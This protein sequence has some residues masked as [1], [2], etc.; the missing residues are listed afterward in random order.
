MEKF[1]KVTVKLTTNFHDVPFNTKSFLKRIV[2]E[3]LHYYE[4]RQRI[5]TRQLCELTNT[6]LLS[7][8]LLYE[9]T[10]YWISVGLFKKRKV[11]LLQGTAYTKPIVMSVVSLLMKSRVG[12]RMI[13]WSYLVLLFLLNR[14]VLFEQFVTNFHPLSLIYYCL[15][16]TKHCKVSYICFTKTLLG[17]VFQ[18]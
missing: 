9:C 5:L 1:D 12:V 14:S 10:S 17:E 11:A 2:Y 18:Y 7:I 16:L 6:A 3:S 15:F 8:L 13:R 4:R